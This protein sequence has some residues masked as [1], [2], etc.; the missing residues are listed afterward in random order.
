MTAFVDASPFGAR[1]PN[2]LKRGVIALTRL[3][4]DNWLGLRLAIL[5]RRIVMSSGRDEAIDTGLWGL[6]LRLYPRRNGCEKN[7]LFTPQMFD[8]TERGMLAREIDEC[9]RRGGDFVFVDIGANVGLY[10]L[11]VAQ[12]AGKRANIL[13]IEPQPGIADRFAF[14]FALNPDLSAVLVRQAVAGEDGD[15]EL[16]IDAR[17][18]G[19]TSLR[20]ERFGHAAERVPVRCRTLLGLLR[21]HGIARIDALKIDVEGAEDVVLT[22]FLAGAP[23]ALL[24][25]WILI[26]DAREAWRSDVFAALR[27]RGYAEIGRSAQNVV[28]ARGRQMEAAA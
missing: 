15:A 13:A 25:G 9:L 5:L 21:D 11:F 3:L 19:G 20:A 18:S 24:P 6:H 4:P 10:S 2:T 12:R 8:V 1:R 16:A 27:Q 14:N 23:D 7:A 22:P 28:M 26:E 17:D